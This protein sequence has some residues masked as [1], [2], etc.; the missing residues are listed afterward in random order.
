MTTTSTSMSSTT[1]AATTPQD[2]AVAA[3][4]ARVVRRV[5]DDFRERDPVA[6]AAVASLLAEVCARSKSSSSVRFMRSRSCLLLLSCPQKWRQRIAC[7]TGVAVGAAESESEEGADAHPSVDN[8]SAEAAPTSTGG[9]DSERAPPG[10]LP[11][12]NRIAAVR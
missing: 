11:S 10:L 1:S 7:Y 6:N 3:F 12:T 9:G 2:A 8:T 4:Y 5:C